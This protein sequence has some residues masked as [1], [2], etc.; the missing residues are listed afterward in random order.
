MNGQA[1]AAEPEGFA[2][3]RERFQRILGWLDGDSSTGLDHAE[4]ERQLDVEG[5]ELLRQ[6]LQDHVDLRAI[7]EGRVEVRDADGSRRTRVETG[8]TRGLGTIFGE[9]TV[10]RRAYREPGRANLHPA[11]AALNL[12]IE[13]Y[14]HGLRHL[15]AIESARGSFD[16]AVEAIDRS[17]GQHLG[18]RQVEDLASRAA[19]DF[20]A[21]YLQR[22][23]PS[24]E[25]GDVQVLSCDGKG[26]VMRPGA[27]RPATAKAA[28]NTNPR[29]A[30]RL[31]KGEKRGRKRM[32]EVGAVYDITP[33][34]RRPADILPGNDR[35]RRDTTPGPS[36][37]N[38]WL[39]ASVV[40]DAAT[41]VTAI[42]DE[43][44]RR[45]PHHLRTRI[46]LVDGN[47]H[48]IQRIQAEA[49]D[50]GITVV[51]IIDFVHVLEY[52]WKAA[53]TFHHE[54]DPAAETWVRKHAQ[55]ILDGHPT[56]VAGAPPTRRHHRRPGHPSPRERRQVRDLP[57]KQADVPGLPDRPQT[58]LADRHRHHRRGLPPPRERPHGP[59]RRPLGTARR[60][61]H[62]Q[63]PGATQQRRLRRLLALPPVEH[64]RGC[65]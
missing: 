65:L 36:A 7:R 25:V 46:A 50:R 21:F 3:A 6:L 8:H 1:V 63:A 20:D 52:I 49:N 53:W 17:T 13:K 5:R 19:V 26:V 16:G 57:D 28:A 42:F 44:D 55:T 15:A 33:V 61:G 40:N 31:S 18:K 9:V 34:A 43:A 56:R 22:Q 35:Q 47:V 32:A 23:A 45:D 2:G 4:L 38:K 48:Q 60:R 27:L 64:H 59:H 58:G 10:T 54:G 62:P 29:L 39:I 30:T 51:I 41:V 12:P 24:G 11:D 14:S 37:R